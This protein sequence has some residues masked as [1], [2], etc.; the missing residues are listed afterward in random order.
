MG[1]V[2]ECGRAG[3][4]RRNKGR[5]LFWFCWLFSYVLLLLDAWFHKETL[6]PAPLCLIYMNLTFLQQ[7]IALHSKRE[8]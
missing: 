1:L 4:L 8:P 5:E 7:V 3:S 6:P 2:L